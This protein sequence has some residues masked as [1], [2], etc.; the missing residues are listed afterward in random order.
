MIIER[1]TAFI[2]LINY[3]IGKL[4]H[5]PIYGKKITEKAQNIPDKHFTREMLSNKSA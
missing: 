3:E 2:A 4:K 1:S 5:C